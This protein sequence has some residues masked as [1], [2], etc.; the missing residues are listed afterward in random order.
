[1]EDQAHSAQICDGELVLVGPV[2]LALAHRL[3]GFQLQI[4]RTLTANGLLNSVKQI[5]TFPPQ[6]IKDKLHVILLLVQLI[7]RYLQLCLARLQ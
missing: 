3:H 2:V 6:Q 4:E 7:K 5:R 1:M